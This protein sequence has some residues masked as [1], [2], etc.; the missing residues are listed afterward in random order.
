[1]NIAR[2]LTGI[3]V[4]STDSIKMKISKRNFNGVCLVIITFNIGLSV[5]YFFYIPHG[6]HLGLLFTFLLGIYGL[7]IFTVVSVGKD[8]Y[9]KHEKLLKRMVIIG[10]FVWLFYETNIVGGF[11]YKSLEMV[12]VIYILVATAL[13]DTLQI[14][15][16]L[17]GGSLIIIYHILLYYYD[18]RVPIMAMQLL[19][20]SPL[21]YKSEVILF[22]MMFVSL[23]ISNQVF[24]N[25]NKKY[26]AI[27]EAQNRKSNFEINIVKEMIRRSSVD[28][29]TNFNKYFTMEVYQKPYYK[30]SGDFYLVDEIRDKFYV[31]LFD[32][33]GHGLE[34]GVFVL[35]LRKE[36]YK[37]LDENIY[38][39]AIKFTDSVN[40]FLDDSDKTTTITIIEIDPKTGNI[41]YINNGNT[42]FLKKNNSCRLLKSTGFGL[43]ARY[44]VLKDNMKNKTMI[45]MTDGI[46]EGVNKNNKPFG[47]DG[48]ISVLNQDGD[49]KENIINKYN[50]HIN[51]SIQDDVTLLVIREKEDE[52]NNINS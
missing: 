6:E 25:I 28:L 44:K 47:I 51:N 24:I 3:N 20:V 32:V 26:Y 5:S 4:L 11:F 13:L 9:N 34:A 10:M 36:L 40:E 49:I 27:I 45:V 22:L 46:I 8:I 43:M 48:M 33:S 23:W 19:K 7:I 30:I 29:P 21:S 52:R 15:I 14:S 12:F 1:M 37:I 50:K 31:Y 41:Q 42:M 35:H 17:I 39:A 18:I 2:F 16:G 38:S